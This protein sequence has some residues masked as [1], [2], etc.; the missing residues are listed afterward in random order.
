MP[1]RKSSTSPNTDWHPALT[2]AN[3]YTHLQLVPGM[4][5]HRVPIHREAPPFFELISPLEMR[6]EPAIPFP[7]AFSNKQIS[8][9]CSNAGPTKRPAELTEFVSPS[10]PVDIFLPPLRI[11]TLCASGFPFT[12]T[13]WL[14]RNNA[15]NPAG[16]PAGNQPYT[17]E[18]Y[19]PHAPP[20]R[21]HS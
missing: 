8:L 17:I 18:I 15:F 21:N 9:Q 13:N 7:L 5:I 6:I 19:Q 16:P 10:G 14:W 12:P 11:D 2:R 4:R 1:V 20:R 3:L